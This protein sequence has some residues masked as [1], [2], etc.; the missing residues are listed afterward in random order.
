ML[1]QAPR[2]GRVR[3][4]RTPASASR[5][6]SRRSSSRRSSRPT[7]APAAS[8]AAPASASRSAASWRTCS[9]ARSSC[10]ARPGV[11]QHVHALPA[12]RL[13]RAADRAGAR[14]A[15][16][17]APVAAGAALRRRRR[18]SGRSSTIPDDRHDIEPGDTILLIVEDDPHYA[19]VLV[20]LARD[21][22]FKVLV[23]MRGAD[24]LD[25]ARAVSSRP[26]SRSTS[27]CPTCWAGRCSA[28]SSRTR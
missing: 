18:R 3:G 14:Q 26:R 2:G 25:L 10:A 5:S 15:M 19:R 23:A 4:R 24:A 7:P 8:T 21:K 6:R 11:G 22:G 20:D 12:A 27:S 28:S 17:P 13:R 1:S 16:P 9:A